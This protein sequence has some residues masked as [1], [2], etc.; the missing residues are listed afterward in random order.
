MSAESLR[1]YFRDAGRIYIPY[2]VRQA[3]TATLVDKR[4]HPAPTY[5]NFHGYFADTIVKP[6]YSCIFAR[7]CFASVFPI[8]VPVLFGGFIAAS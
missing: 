8:S 7:Y 3:M 4:Y 6:S 1:Y 2:G 5:N